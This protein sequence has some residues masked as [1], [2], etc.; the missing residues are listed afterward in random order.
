MEQCHFCGNRN[1]REATCQYTYKRDEKY[2]MVDQ[3][4]CRQC[5][6]CGEQYFVANVLK[7]IEQEFE[8]I[9]LHGKRVKRELVIPVEQF[10]E[11]GKTP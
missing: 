6:Y 8:A 10:M 9:H 1:F 2:L 3:V 4:P 7:V 5:E 11:M